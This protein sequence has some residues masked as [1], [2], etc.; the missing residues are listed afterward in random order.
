MAAILDLEMYKSRQDLS[1]TS[2]EE[3][4]IRQT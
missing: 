2:G 3:L 1:A 4:A